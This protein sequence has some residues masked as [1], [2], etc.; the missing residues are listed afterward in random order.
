MDADCLGFIVKLAAHCNISTGLPIGRDRFSVRDAAKLTG[1]S[2]SRLHNDRERTGILNRIKAWQRDAGME[3]LIHD[4]DGMRLA[5][6]PNRR[7]GVAEKSPHS[8]PEEPAF[9]ARGARI[10]GQRSPHSGPEEPD[11]RASDYW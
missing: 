4:R 5:V 2:R 11:M 8:G 7:I 3:Y 9:R 6:D 10:P 1:V